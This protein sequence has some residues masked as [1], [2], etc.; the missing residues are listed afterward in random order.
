M[1]LPH[2]CKSLR[3][4]RTCPP[5]R[6]GVK[7]LWRSIV[8]SVKKQPR[9]P[10][11]DFTGKTVGVDISVWLHVACRDV[12]V[13]TCYLQ[14]NGQFITSKEW[15]IL[16]WARP[17]IELSK[18]Y[19]KRYKWSQSTFSSIAWKA[20]GQGA[21]NK[22]YP[23]F[24]P[25]LSC[26]WL[27]SNDTMDKCE[28]ISPVCPR[29]EKV[30]T[31]DHTFLC[32]FRLSSQVKFRDH[33]LGHLIDTHTSSPLVSAIING[34]DKYSR[35][36]GGGIL[37]G[38][39]QPTSDTC[40]ML[41]YYQTRIGWHHLFR[42]FVSQVW[43]DHQY[44]YT[45]DK[46]TEQS[47]CDTWKPRLIRFL[48]MHAYILWTDKCSQIQQVSRREREQSRRWAA[49]LVTAMY[50]YALNVSAADREIFFGIPLEEMLAKT[51]AAT[52]LDWHKAMQ[53]VLKRAI[54]DLKKQENINQLNLFGKRMQEAPARA[55][56]RPQLKQGKR[57]GTIQP[58]LDT[59]S[60]KPKEKKPRKRPK[61]G[62][63]GRPSSN[64]TN[65]RPC[66]YRQQQPGLT[67]IHSC[68]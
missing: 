35:K 51:T 26:S 34:L 18:Y 50:D 1:M 19:M 47:P 11:S 68:G 31:N 21:N 67:D 23:D 17:K 52:L 63:Y 46:Q 45:L 41:T 16:K 58:R 59:I 42:G 3:P 39:P 43:A 20:S 28:G 33:L 54:I 30:E 44:Y 53:K 60:R 57:R 64:A 4:Y 38:T 10:L 36:Y 14:H 37:S 29:C 61:Q 15:S 62:F 25:Q 8:P 22:N 7:D 6:M 5:C 9:Q 27:S 66:D 48:H 2:F 12:N 40:N 32:I 24:F 55:A 65:S 13:A 56:S 49:T